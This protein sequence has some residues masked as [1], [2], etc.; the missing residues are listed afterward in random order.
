MFDFVRKHTKIMQ[1]L[2]FLLIFPSFV[3][4]GLEGYSRMR[5][6][7]TVVASV[8]G[9]DILQSELDNAHKIQVDRMRASMPN[10][11]A[12]LFDSSIA[13]QATLD[14][15]VRERLLQVAAQKMHLSVSDQRLANELQQNPSIAAL[16]RP[17]GSLDLERYRQ[18]LGTQ[19][20]TPESFEAQVRSDLSTRQVMA[21][22][23]LSL[24]HI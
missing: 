22:L 15:L 20:F 12:K 23:G 18:L 1:F 10:L 8:N 17:D 9:V 4:F 21:G 19:G 11:D 16:R 13:K 6:K 3:L 24:I 7:G 5:E 2:L 14:R